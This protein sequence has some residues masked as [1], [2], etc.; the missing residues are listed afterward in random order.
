MDCLIEI[1]DSSDHRLIRLVGRLT[2]AEVHDLHQACRD[3]QHA[4]R[5]NLSELVSVDTL[6]LEV[7]HGLQR[8]GAHFIEVPVY[9]Q[10]KLDALSSRR[11]KGSG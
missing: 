8:D 4:V 7:L 2:A 10:L 1:V 6:G 9:I 3:S 11:R 5:L